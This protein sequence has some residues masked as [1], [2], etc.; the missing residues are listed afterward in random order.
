MGWGS[1]TP[2]LLSPK[3]FPDG[4]FAMMPVLGCPSHEE[5]Y[6]SL[7]NQSSSWGQAGGSK[8]CRGSAPARKISFISLVTYGPKVFLLSLSQEGLQFL[9]TGR[10]FPTD[11]YICKDVNRI[12]NGHLW[13]RFANKQC[14]HQ[15]TFG[16]PRRMCS[17]EQ[18]EEGFAVLP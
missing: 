9:K 12:F 8:G 10:W 11:N 14:Q 2:F 4:P 5:S 13:R 3:S 1:I 18:F 15:V 16:H 7:A 6:P 17:T